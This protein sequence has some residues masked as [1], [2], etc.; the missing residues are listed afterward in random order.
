MQTVKK[1]TKL[2]NLINIV[3][4]SSWLKS[5]HSQ[6]GGSVQKRSSDTSRSRRLTIQLSFHASNANHKTPDQSEWISK[7]FVLWCQPLTMSL[8]CSGELLLQHNRKIGSPLLHTTVE[9]CQSH[10]CCRDLLLA[11]GSSCSDP[12]SAQEVLETATS[13]ADEACGLSKV[14]DGHSYVHILWDLRQPGIVLGQRD[15]V[16]AGRISIEGYWI[17]KFYWN[18]TSTQYIK[19]ALMDE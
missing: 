7:I 4:R 10:E 11:V 8:R 12:P 6:G 15:P 9:F 18:S 14:T 17:N 19:N 13:P 5:N 1:K 16:A 3:T 2:P